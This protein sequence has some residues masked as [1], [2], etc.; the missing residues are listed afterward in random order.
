MPKAK[1]MTAAEFAQYAESIPKDQYD[2]FNAM[3]AFVEDVV[4]E[5][6]AGL[7]EANIVDGEGL[8]PT[9]IAFNAIWRAEAKKIRDAAKF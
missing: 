7:I 8:N 5:R 9:L 6:D 4:T 1:P 3:L 2:K